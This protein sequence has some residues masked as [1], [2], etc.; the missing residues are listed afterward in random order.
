MKIMNKVKMAQKFKGSI[1]SAAALIKHEVSVLNGLTHP[2][3]V[4]NLKIFHDDRRIF[5][6]MEFCS[7]GE[8]F[9]LIHKSR[10][11]HL[12][13]NPRGGLSTTVTRFIT[14][15][16]V[17][18]LEFLHVNCVVYRDLKPE[19]CLLDEKGHVKIADFGLAKRLVRSKNYRTWTNCGTL[20]YQ[21]PEMLLNREYSFEPDWWSLGV[22]I[23]EML[24]CRSPWG[25]GDKLQEVFYVSQSIMSVNIKW[26]PWRSIDPAGRDLI[27]KLICFN[28]SKRWNAQKVKKH[29]FFK[30]ISWKDALNKRI[31]PPYGPTRASRAD[32]PSKTAAG[33]KKT[34]TVSTEIVEDDAQSV[35]FQTY[36]ES[37]EAGGPQMGHKD[38]G[39]WAQHLDLIIKQWNVGDRGNVAD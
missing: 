16:M 21:A 32:A 18:A 27:E 14:T 26:G 15:E 20:L 19:N 29:K 13:R 2:F 5:M 28:P 24:T 39:I 1:A 6:I 8:L 11:R 10:N 23:F 38:I 9:R 4:N 31:N 3:V 37:M 22:V 17:L 34:V 33:G 12:M 35:C 36:P 30:D 25:E 7:G